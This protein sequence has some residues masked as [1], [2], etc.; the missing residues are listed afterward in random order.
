M[1]YKCPFEQVSDPNAMQPT[2]H[3]L[4]RRRLFTFQGACVHIE[5]SLAGSAKS[6]TCAACSRTATETVPESRVTNC[7][8][9]DR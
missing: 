2:R 6:A 8:W 5:T 9:L 4:S 3:N 1:F 7:G